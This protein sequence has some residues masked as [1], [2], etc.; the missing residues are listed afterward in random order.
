MGH[1]A[2]GN[3]TAFVNF[4]ENWWTSDWSHKRIYDNWWLGP[5]DGLISKAGVYDNAPCT[6]T[7]NDLQKTWPEGFKRTTILGATNL[8][9]G[10][11]VTYNNT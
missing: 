8:I 4:M 3:E 2:K 11:F 10:K 1:Y 7:I 5:I 9:D 6:D